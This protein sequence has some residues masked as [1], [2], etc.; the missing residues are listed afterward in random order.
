MSALS[1]V[2]SIGYPDHRPSSWCLC[3]L[4]FKYRAAS[5]KSFKD[6]LLKSCEKGQNAAICFVVEVYLLGCSMRRS[7]NVQN[8]LLCQRRSLLLIFGHSCCFSSFRF[9]WLLVLSGTTVL[10]L[11][12]DLCSC[13]GLCWGGS[14]RCC[15]LCLSWL[16]VEIGFC[17]YL[18][19][20]ERHVA[21]CQYSLG[22]QGLLVAQVHDAFSNFGECE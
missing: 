15:C 1:T 20:D 17:L 9:S 21:R 22:I 5:H 3:C 10:F 8:R 19:L 6:D 14:K 2:E 4:E 7:L 11:R 16:A 18:L 12:P 13:K